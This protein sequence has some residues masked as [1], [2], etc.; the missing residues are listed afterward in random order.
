[1]KARAWQAFLTD[2]RRHHGKVLFTVTELANV[3]G[4][5]LHALNVEL[6]RLVRQGVL[7]RYAHGLYGLP[8]EVSPEQL[9][10]AMDSSAYMT[11]AYA[12]Y[13]HNLITQAPSVITCFTRRRHNR[14]RQRQTAIGRFT[15]VCVSPRVY[16]QPDGLPLAG[17][18][19]ALC[20]YVYL[21]GRRGTSAPSLL[22]FRGLDR[23]DGVALDELGPRYPKS[24]MKRVHALVAARS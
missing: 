12:L 8:G 14:S 24:T 20:D 10:A 18:G 13:R 6:G 21:A 11:G 22:T 4:A 5:S 15:F 3:A 23:I 7:T 1:M 16:A 19:Q 9:V 17:P 2:Q